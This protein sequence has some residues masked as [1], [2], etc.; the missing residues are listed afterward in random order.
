MD[1]I[2]IPLDVGLIGEAIAQQRAVNVADAYMH[3]KFNKAI[4][5]RTG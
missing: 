5:M 3:P 1:E 2:C 4:D